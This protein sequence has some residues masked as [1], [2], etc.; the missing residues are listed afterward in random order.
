MSAE[1]ENNTPNNK[2]RRRSAWLGPLA[3]VLLFLVGMLVLSLFFR[4]SFIEVVNASEYSDEEIIRAS[5]VEKG[6]NLFFVDRF[7]AASM[8]FSDLPYMDTV[9]IRRQLPGKIIIQAEGSAPVAYMSL[10]EEYWLLDRFGKPLGTV[11]R[12]EAEKYAEIR[13]LE[14]YTVIAGTEM[15]VEGDNE[16]RLAY[17]AALLTPLQAE[18]MLPYIQWIDLKNVSNPSLRLDGRINVF[19]GTQEDMAYKI[20][21]L[22]DVTEKLSRDDTGTLYYASGNTWTFSPD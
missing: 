22:R 2:V 12:T 1:T 6:A 16:A 20:A 21:L 5:G 11:S 9:S 7:K 8:I 10:D 13:N 17:Y 15:L 4:V 3:L 19:L 14:P 18:G